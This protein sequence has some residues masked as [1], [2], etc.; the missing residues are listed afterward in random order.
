MSQFLVLIVRVL[1]V[2]HSISQYIYGVLLTDEFILD[3]SVV[4]LYF[5]KV[6]LS[7]YP[8]W[9]YLWLLLNLVLYLLLPDRAVHLFIVL[10]DHTVETIK[11][12]KS[13]DYEIETYL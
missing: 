8:P 12:G 11:K 2:D 13:M 7:L 6:L 9:R 10:V 4:I 1:F 3:F 5:Q